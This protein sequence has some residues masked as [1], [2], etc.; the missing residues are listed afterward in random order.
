MGRINYNGKS[1][2]QWEEQ[3]TMGRVNLIL[4]DLCIKNTNHPFYRRFRK[5]H[6]NKRY[7][8]IKD[9]SSTIIF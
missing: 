9:G 7:W 4:N 5:L 8:M 3:I 1:R 2:L 6:T